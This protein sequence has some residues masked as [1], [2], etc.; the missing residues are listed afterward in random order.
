MTLALRNKLIKCYR[1][2]CGALL[3]IGQKTD[4]KKRKEQSCWRRTEKNSR[5]TL[6][7]DLSRRAK[8]QLLMRKK[9]KTEG[10]EDGCTTEI[11]KNL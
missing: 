5:E 6:N 3:F 9:E 2:A 10:G 1:I 8:D 7:E 4:I 11:S